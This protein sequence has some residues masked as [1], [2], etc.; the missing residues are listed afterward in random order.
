MSMF[1]QCILV[2]SLVTITCPYNL[3]P[4]SLKLNFQSN[5]AFFPQCEKPNHG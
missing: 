2:R 3:S 1:C 4:S 5:Y